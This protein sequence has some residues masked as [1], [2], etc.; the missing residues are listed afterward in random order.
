MTPREN[1]IQFAQSFRV[2]EHGGIPAGR[3]LSIGRHRVFSGKTISSEHDGHD[4]FVDAV[5][6]PE[7]P[8]VVIVHDEARSQVR[9]EFEQDL[10][11]PI[12]ALI[13]GWRRIQSRPARRARR[14][15]AAPGPTRGAAATENRAWS[16]AT[17]KPA[18]SRS[19]VDTVERFQGGEREVILIGATESDRNI[20][21]ST[22]SLCSIRAD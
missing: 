14:G 16:N 19:A 22:E 9:N 8:M 10:I 18:R 7:Q 13:G 17:Q 11:S 4:E 1:W 15:G 20:C 3:D 5:L 21:L 12:L 2:H 6:R